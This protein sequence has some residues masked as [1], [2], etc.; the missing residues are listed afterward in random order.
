V[1]RPAAAEVDATSSSPSQATIRAA[2]FSLAGKITAVFFLVLIVMGAVAVAA[3]A[4]PLRPWMV[5]LL[6][7]G[8]GLALGAWLLD[9][10]LRPFKRTL[11]GLSDGIRSFHD[12]DFSVRLPSHRRDELGELARLYNRVGEVLLEERQDRHREQAHHQGMVGTEQPGIARD[13]GRLTR[14]GIEGFH[15]CTQP[16]CPTPR[17]VLTKC[18]KKTPAD[19][20]SGTCRTPGVLC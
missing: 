1:K 20:G 9:R 14:I 7:V 12:G 3:T 5:F 4:L 19:D 10:L 18:G 16:I 2:R 6:I 8:L 15:V 13:T 17:G 11:D